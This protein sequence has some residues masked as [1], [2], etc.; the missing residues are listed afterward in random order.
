MKKLILSAV[1][2]SVLCTTSVP[3]AL[4]AQEPVP[5]VAEQ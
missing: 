4:A 5:Y 3:Y 1:C 2:C